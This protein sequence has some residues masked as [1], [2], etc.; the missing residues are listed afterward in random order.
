MPGLV[1]ERGEGAAGRPAVDAGV[2]EVADMVCRRTG[3]VL[4]E[5]QYAELPALVEEGCALFGRTD[6][7]DYLR[8]LR[9]RSRTPEF[10]FL[11]DR[12]TISE[13]YFFRDA[14]QM[15]LLQHRLLPEIIA[16]KRLSGDLSLRIWSAGCAEGQEIYTM[17]MLL[18]ELIPD[19]K[20]WCISLLAT[21]INRS[22]LK[23]AAVGKYR[24][25]SLRS[26]PPGIRMHYFH[27][28]EYEFVICDD[29]RRM[30]RFSYL[31]LAED[32]FPS[33]HGGQGN[34]DLVLCRNVLVYQSPERVPALISRLAGSLAAG[35][36]LLLGASDHVP[37][38]LRSLLRVHG[39]DGSIHYQRRADGILLK[40]G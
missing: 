18:R 7:N 37:A 21:D 40:T 9:T 20:S 16:D 13:S 30:V 12:I 24:K 3:I 33:L 14:S 23:K 22:A 15:A 10:D 4:L 29:V 25:W 27:R 32:L 38:S 1:R 28:A 34:L 31:N 11:V 17:A 26:T 19:L 2:H 6:R 39:P 36:A 5:H 8:V 35:G